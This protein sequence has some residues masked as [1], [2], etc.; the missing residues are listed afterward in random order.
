MRDDVCCRN[1]PEWS[2]DVSAAPFHPDVAFERD[3][4]NLPGRIA[5]KADTRRKI[6]AFERPRRV[7]SVSQAVIHA[8][9]LWSH[10]SHARAAQQHEEST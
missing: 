7:A 1:V 3:P 5:S 8:L 10:E 9:A 4:G 6:S 2:K